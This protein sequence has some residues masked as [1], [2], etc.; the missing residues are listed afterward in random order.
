[1]AHNTK[2]KNTLLLLQDNSPSE[3]GALGV[4]PSSAIPPA[5]PLSGT[6][7][8]TG[9]PWRTNPAVKVWKLFCHRNPSRVADPFDPTG[10]FATTRVYHSRPERSKANPTEAVLDR[11]GGLYLMLRWFPT[12]HISSPFPENTLRN[13]PLGIHMVDANATRCIPPVRREARSER[14]PC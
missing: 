10:P 2:A 4:P 13:Q 11:P 5:D 8:I 3:R 6:G 7:G 9:P 1:M 12:Q 14:E